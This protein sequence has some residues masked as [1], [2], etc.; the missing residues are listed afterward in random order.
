MVAIL[1]HQLRDAHPVGRR[2]RLC[3][4]VACSEITKEANLGIDTQSGAE[5][6]DDFGNDQ[7][8]HDQRPRVRLEQL[9]ACTMMAVVAIDVGV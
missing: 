1:H 3:N 5:Q 6:V 2:N 7:S 9:K 4:Q 8:R